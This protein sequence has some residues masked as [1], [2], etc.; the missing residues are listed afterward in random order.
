MSKVFGV[1]SRSSS[2][3]PLEDPSL[4]ITGTAAAMRGSPPRSLGMAGKR[5]QHSLSNPTLF[6]IYKDSS[7]SPQDS[8]IIHGT[9]NNRGSKENLF[10]AE[11]TPDVEHPSPVP[12]GAEEPVKKK[13]KKRLLG[14]S[15]SEKRQQVKSLERP[16]KVLDHYP[17]QDQ[18]STGTPPPLSP[19]SIGRS[20]KEG[21]KKKE[22]HRDRSSV[23]RE[24]EQALAL[25]KLTCA[26]YANQV[27]VKALE[28]KQAL[29][30]EAFLIRELKQGRQFLEE[31]EAKVSSSSSI[32]E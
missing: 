19:E 30:R 20:K 32:W 8:P 31:L 9:L 16:I 27:E 29:Q 4:S 24:L 10:Q 28:L 11:D 2:G 14:R 17:Q 5:Q 12:G 13:K 21:K 1:R 7:V 6:D 22:K 25:S 26:D 15:K 18:D 3:P 23:E